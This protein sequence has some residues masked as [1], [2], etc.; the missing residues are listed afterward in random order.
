ML[1][2]IDL[3]SNQF[4]HLKLIVKKFSL[5]ITKNFDRTAKE[6]MT[7]KIFLKRVK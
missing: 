7:K 2:N 3:Q 4:F 6:K 1:V 5:Q